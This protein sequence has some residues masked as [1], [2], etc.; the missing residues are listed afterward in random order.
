MSSH[1]ANRLAIIEIA[2]KVW[3]MLN[4]RTAHYDLHSMARAQEAHA[5]ART[6]PDVAPADASRDVTWRLYTEDRSTVPSIVADYFDGATMFTAT[7]LWK[8]QTEQS[9]VVE[10]IAPITSRARII[11]VARRIIEL[12]NQEAVLVTVAGPFGLQTFMVR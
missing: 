1:T 2:R 7:G 12:N 3:A 11:A 10:V 4:P 5:R 9:V 6:A 8:G